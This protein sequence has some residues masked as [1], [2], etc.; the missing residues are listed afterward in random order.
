ME[1]RVCVI[2]IP[3]GRLVGKMALLGLIGALLGL[4]LLQGGMTSA[5]VSLV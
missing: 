5:C 3:V 2:N 4:L 1:M